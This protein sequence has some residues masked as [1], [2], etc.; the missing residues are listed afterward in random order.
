[1]QPGLCIAGILVTLAAGAGCSDRRAG[2]APDPVTRTSAPAEAAESPPTETQ[3]APETTAESGEAVADGD[4]GSATP[5][6]F[7]GDV[8]APCAS[9]PPSRPPGSWLAYHRR[10]RDPQ[11]LR[12]VHLVAEGEACPGDNLP[13]H[14]RPI[15]PPPL[16]L[17]MAGDGLDDL[18]R[19]LTTERLAA[20]QT[21]TI[22]ASPHRGGTAIGAG[23]GE[24]RCS[25]SDI[26]ISEVTEPDRELFRSLEGILRRAIAAQRS[27]N[28]PALLLVPLRGMRTTGASPRLRLRLDNGTARGARVRVRSVTPMVSHG[29]FEVSVPTLRIEVTDVPF[30]EVYPYTNRA[31]T[32]VDAWLDVAPQTSRL[33]E[34]IVDHRVRHSF[35]AV[36]RYRVVLEHGGAGEESVEE[37]VEV[38]VGD[39]IRHPRQPR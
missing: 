15:S 8:V 33:L 17:R 38:I 18:W 24:V 22:E 4:P 23:W 3:S 7:L 36:H 39:A 25:V 20:V 29:A 28:R 32:S 6:R 27:G 2:S 5:A 31:S 34:I 14:L 13:G 30:R 26:R 10:G 1:M 9:I 11:D 21:T 12:R 35:G 19:T 16:C 37:S